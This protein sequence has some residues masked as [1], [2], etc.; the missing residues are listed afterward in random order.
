MNER[1]ELSWCLPGVPA[2][3]IHLTRSRLYV[4]NGVILLGLLTGRIDDPGMRGTHG[5]DAAVSRDTIARDHIL[6]ASARVA[7][8]RRNGSIEYR[9]PH[10]CYSFLLRS[11][12]SA[13]E[14][15]KKQ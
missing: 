5:V 9:A 13:A 10:C 4:E 2:Q 12:T 8:V 6:Q 11:W 15:Y 7:M 14:F 1:S 3:L